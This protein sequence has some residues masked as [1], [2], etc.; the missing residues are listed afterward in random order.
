VGRFTSEDPIGFAGG[1]VNFF[2]YAS[3][4]ATNIIDPLGLILWYADKASENAMKTHIQLLMTTAK[5]RELLKRL[6]NDPEL[7]LIHSGSGP[8]GPAYQLGND[9]YVDPSFKP[10]IET[11]C[12][13]KAASTTRVLSHEL[14]HL[15]GTKDDGLGGM[16]NIN[17]WENP[18]MYPLEGYR[19]ITY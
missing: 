7:Y 16:N 3:N 8:Y 6:H 12:G 17:T 2:A 19:R 4:N 15:S 13:P 5:G 1:D 9:V 18:I 14:G 11:D 10:T